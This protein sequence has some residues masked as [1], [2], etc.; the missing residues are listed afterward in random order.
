[1]M[2]IER[3]EKEQKMTQDRASVL[4]GTRLG[5]PSINASREV[6]AN[7]G[8]TISHWNKGVD[9]SAG[10]HR[11]HKEMHQY[12]RRGGM[13]LS[14]STSRCKGVE[15]KPVEKLTVKPLEPAKKKN[16]VTL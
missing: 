13:M 16:S 14:S 6:Q 7:G 2:G 12:C 8:G 15:E 3:E 11:N 10:G 5:G 1:M 9:L 4:G